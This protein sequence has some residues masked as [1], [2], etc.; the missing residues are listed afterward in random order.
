M[1]F[2]QLAGIYTALSA[3]NLIVIEYFVWPGP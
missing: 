1:P 2:Q 3:I